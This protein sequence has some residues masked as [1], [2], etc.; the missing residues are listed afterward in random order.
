MRTLK[1]TL[2]LILVLSMMV[3][4]CAF[5]AFAADYTDAD[6]IEHK[7]A[8]TIMTGMGVIKGDDTGAFNPTGTLNR[9][10]AAC[11]IAR[12]LGMDD[13]KAKS[14][15]TDLAGYGWAE[16]AIAVCEAEGIVVGVGGG[17]FN[18]G[19]TL[20]GAQWGK[21]LLK[22][23]GYEDPDLDNAAKWE[24]AVAKGVKA[25]GLK[26]NLAS[27]DGTAPISRDDA[28]QMTWDCI[29][30]YSP[31]GKTV[32]SYTVSVGGA[33]VYT[34]ND[35]LLALGAMISNPGSTISKNTQKSG[36]LGAQNYGLA[37]V[38]T[39]D[40]FGR[41]STVYTN[42]KTKGTAGYVEYGSIGDEPVKTYTTATR[43]SKIASDLGATTATPIQLSVVNNGTAM[44]GGAYYDAYKTANAT[45]GYAVTTL[46]VA[47]S[48]IEVYKTTAGYK[49]IVIDYYV[50]KL[51]NGDVVAAKAAT[52]TSD[53]QKA[54]I[55]LNG[56]DEFKTD[57]FKVGDVVLYTKTATGVATAVKAEAFTGA[58][59]AVNTA[60]Q[61]IKVDGTSYK[62]NANTQVSTTAASN[63]ANPGI[64]N[65]VLAPS[66]Q[67]CTFYK[68][69]NGN[70][71][72]VEPGVA[73]TV[74]VD[75]VYLIDVVSKKA[76]DKG[77][78]TDLFG[79]GATKTEAQA[80]A[81]IL[82]LKSGEVKVVDIA[83][84]TNAS[85]KAVYLAPGGAPSGN[86]VKTFDS[87]NAYN[88]TTNPVVYDFTDSNGNPSNIFT[89]TIEDGAYALGVK[90]IDQKTMTVAT[91]GNAKV[92]VD[93]ATSYTT[94]K[95]EVTVVEY[96]VS[97]G[98]PTGATV[99]TTSGMANIAAGSY[100]GVVTISDGYV[101]KVLAVKAKTAATTTET[102]AIYAGKGE[103]AIDASTGN[104]IYYYK[105]AVNG[106][107]KSLADNDGKYDGVNNWV[108]GNV[109]TLTI[110]DTN[111]TVTGTAKTANKAGVKVEKLQDEYVVFS[112]DTTAYKFASNFTAVN[113]S[114]YSATA[115]TVS[116]KNTV[117][118]FLNSNNQVA[119]AIVTIVP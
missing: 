85:G 101:T 110:N 115:L 54:Y 22:A 15:F 47:G 29:H 87:R 105:F 35:E 112:G 13:I 84:G 3:G 61:Y 31:D 26:K 4:L 17:K 94:S 58:I 76:S 50:H 25:A 100:K 51:V 9:A 72:Y 118:I 34:G 44:G 108:A 99:T 24:I 93:G 106:E 109:Y 41:E 36:T 30:D 27:F 98:K 2:C 65:G 83:I 21:M 59:T 38:S 57:A 62:L 19:G 92:T 113:K 55:K 63:Q 56:T 48:T 104:P 53:A 68:D 90:A 71:I 43:D 80:Q 66:T 32:E 117:D 20:T 88:A 77:D 119:F 45:A 86:T 91:K 103:T 69:A 114:D 107:V 42:G 95:T 33:A 5:G 60:D 28:C 12:I 14:T 67:I 7:D 52:A 78:G 6:K 1:K 40:A 18:P 37:E 97:N 79:T 111:G 116:T 10:E 70:V 8:V 81:K 46:G 11:I 23:A 16:G 73:A 82:D 102:Y 96:T 75:Y 64:G 89:Y 39:K 74:K 49:A